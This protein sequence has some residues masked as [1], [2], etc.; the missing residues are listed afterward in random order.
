MYSMAN[1]NQYFSQGQGLSEQ[2]KVAGIT[3]ILLI[4]VFTRYENASE[5]Q[6]EVGLSWFV[7]ESK[8][9]RAMFSFVPSTEELIMGQVD[10]LHVSIHC[11]IFC[12]DLAVVFCSLQR[13]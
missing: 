5:S 4:Q 11:R 6:V 9:A 3:K 7:G 8:S 13:N 1:C 12:N 10:F 2:D